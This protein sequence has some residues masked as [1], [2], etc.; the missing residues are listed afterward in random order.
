[1]ATYTAA[2]LEDIAKHF[3]RQ[4]AIARRNAS[5]SRSVKDCTKWS[6]EAGV[7]NTAADILRQTKITEQKDAA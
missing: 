4:G 2:S 3:D 7:W 5:A 1:M 6:A